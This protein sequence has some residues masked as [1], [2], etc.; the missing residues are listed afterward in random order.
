[1]L[2]A[3][4]ALVAGA[5]VAPVADFSPVQL[6]RSA[7]LTVAAHLGDG[8][9]GAAVRTVTSG[10]PAQTPGFG[11]VP[12]SVPDLL[13]TAAQLASLLLALV[14]V[15]SVRSQAARALPRRRGPPGLAFTD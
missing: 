7:H 14:R 12:G 15:P 9:M 13:L 10:Q 5:L 1:M 6:D 2:I 3:A 4:V 8:P 11:S